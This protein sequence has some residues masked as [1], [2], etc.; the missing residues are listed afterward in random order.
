M[1]D[2]AGSHPFA[3]NAKEW[4]TPQLVAARL[5]SGPF[6]NL[7]ELYFSR[8]LFS[9]VSACVRACV[10]SAPSHPFAKNAK[11]WGTPEFGLSERQ[12]T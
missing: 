3:E 7:C 6:Q 9:R 8:G 2:G 5:K 4:G 12:V 11:E 1:L 10:D